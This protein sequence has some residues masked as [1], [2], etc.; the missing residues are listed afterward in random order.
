MKKYI[1]ILAFI[2]VGIAIYIFSKNVFLNVKKFDT[3]FE[4]AK[5]IKDIRLTKSNIKVYDFKNNE[6]TL[7]SL[8][9]HQKPI[10]IHLWA[11]WCKPCLDDF[12]SLQKFYTLKKDSIDL[13]VISD[14]PNEV[15]KRFL[16]TKNAPKLPF[17]GLEKSNYFLSIDSL[18]IPFN[19]VIKDSVIVKSFIGKTDWNTINVSDLI[20]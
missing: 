4:T 9:N 16:N 1:I 20:Q 14:E 5:K 6:D 8:S 3:I 19:T 7:I 17:Y 15:Q 11:T 10:I 18:T 12:D 2:I 13:F